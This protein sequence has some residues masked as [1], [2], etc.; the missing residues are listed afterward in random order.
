MWGICNLYLHNSRFSLCICFFSCCG[1]DDGCHDYFICT[2]TSH[3]TI[4]SLY[5]SQ[6]NERLQ[7]F[8]FESNWF[9]T[10]STTTIR[11]T[12]YN[13]FLNSSSFFVFLT[14]WNL[15]AK[16]DPLVCVGFVFWKELFNC[17]LY[18]FLKGLF[19][20]MLGEMSTPLFLWLK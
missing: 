11:E 13:F 14:C 8:I 20:A 19:H 2:T 18:F 10:I 15:C 12:I 6:Q 9:A 1:T 3:F 7:N 4:L 17:F 5:W 16:T